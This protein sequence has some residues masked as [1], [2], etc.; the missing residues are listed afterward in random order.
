MSPSFVWAPCA[1]SEV[2]VEG[3][4]E[5]PAWSTS[6]GFLRPWLVIGASCDRCRHVAREKHTRRARYEIG[7]ACRGTAELAIARTIHDEAGAPGAVPTAFRSRAGRAVR[8]DCPFASRCVRRPIRAPRRQ[9]CERGA[10]RHP[11]GMPL[12]LCVSHRKI[13]AFG[14][15]ATSRRADDSQ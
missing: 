7:R 9:D 15:G 2:D 8:R 10:E 5:G 3:L 12:G 4:I 14:A 13:F 11:S 6:N 1:H